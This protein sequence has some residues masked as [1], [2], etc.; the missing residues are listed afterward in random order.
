[1]GNK[2][3]IK[4]AGGVEGTHAVILSL[5]A[6]QAELNS[7]CY[8]VRFKSGLFSKAKPLCFENREHSLRRPAPL[9]GLKLI[10]RPVIYRALL[11]LMS[12]PVALVLVPPSFL[13]KITHLQKGFYILTL[14]NDGKHF[15][16]STY[17]EKC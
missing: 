1:M 4:I 5:V 15:D 13:N 2:L 10:P 3:E 16:M 7:S 8:S 11:L 6:R 14:R 9:G 17:P 12:R